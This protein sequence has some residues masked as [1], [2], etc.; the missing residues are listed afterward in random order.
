MFNTKR[1]TSLHYFNRKV[2]NRKVDFNTVYE[3][4]WILLPGEKSVFHRIGEGNENN[5][6]FVSPDGHHEAVFKLEGNELVLVTDPLNAR[7]YNYSGPLEAYG[8]P[9]IGKDILPYYLLCNTPEDFWDIKVRLE[10][11]KANFNFIMQN[12]NNNKEIIEELYGKLEI[13]TYNQLRELYEEQGG[14]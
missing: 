14:E 11:G 3:E 4:N 12:Y 5:L 8:I 10:I 6:K 1:K 2:T 7:S 13:D 9:H